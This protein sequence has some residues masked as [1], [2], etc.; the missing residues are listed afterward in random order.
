VGDGA[1]ALLI[2]VLSMLGVGPG[3]ELLLWM[4][5]VQRSSGALALVW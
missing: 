5:V 2:E 1:V 4:S 3:R